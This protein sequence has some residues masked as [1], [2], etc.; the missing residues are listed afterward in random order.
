MV[1]DCYETIGSEP[2]FLSKTLDV[3]NKKNYDHNCGLYI[4]ALIS[5]YTCLFFVFIKMLQSG[6]TRSQS[7]KKTH[8][9]IF[10]IGS[11]LSRMAPWTPWIDIIFKKFD[12]YRF[13][14]FV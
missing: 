13:L 14:R 7:K 11:G 9:F 10:G 12:A 5:K 2:I 1:S 6:K 4:L 3:G 8:V